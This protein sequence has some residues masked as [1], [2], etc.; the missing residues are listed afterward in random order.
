MKPK[1][2]ALELVEKFKV[3]DYDWIAQG[4]LYCVKKSALIV[5]DE[6]FEF[7]HNDFKPK[8]DLSFR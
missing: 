4:N 8:F 1:E 2:K 5:V 3:N 6:I 7:V